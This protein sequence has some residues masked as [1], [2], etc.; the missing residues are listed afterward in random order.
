MDLLDLGVEPVLK[1]LQFITS[2]LKF[3]AQVRQLE[4]FR[5]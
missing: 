3:G 2:L 4:L 1:F 5:I